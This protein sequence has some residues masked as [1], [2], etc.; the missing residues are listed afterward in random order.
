MPLSA[1]PE[2]KS[3][4]IPSKWEASKIMKLARAIKAGLI[5]PGTRKVKPSTKIYDIWTLTD[6]VELRN[7]IP[8][9]KLALPEN[10]ESYNPPEE[11]LLSKEEEEQW[12]ALDPEDRPHNFLPKKHD[13]LRAVSSYS[14]FIQERFER[15]LDLYLCP[16]TIKQKVV[17]D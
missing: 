9:P 7:H 15:C 2:P 10:N 6:D 4:F 1:A 13:T 5:V 11:Y 12:K 3:R 14:R 17:L 16:R 8:A